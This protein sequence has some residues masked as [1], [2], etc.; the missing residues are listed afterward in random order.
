MGR[1]LVEC[2]RSEESLKKGPIV[3]ET[4][5]FSASPVLCL[6][7]ERAHRP[8]MGGVPRLARGTC[9]SGVSLCTGGGIRVDRG[10]LSSDLELAVC[11][12]IPNGVL[13]KQRLLVQQLQR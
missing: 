10:D 3:N 7:T 11:K 4:V 13:T 12:R 6:E 2:R 1:R 5:G 9:N 8:P